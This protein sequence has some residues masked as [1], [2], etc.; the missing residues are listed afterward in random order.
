MLVKVKEGT[1]CRYF[2]KSG[3]HQYFISGEAYG[4]IVDSCIDE[5]NRELYTVL[6]GEDLLEIPKEEVHHC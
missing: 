3:S 5:K 1:W 4:L 2:D 6:L